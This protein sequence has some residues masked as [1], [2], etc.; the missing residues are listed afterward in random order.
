MDDLL[1]FPLNYLFVFLW[2]LITTFINIIAPL[3][4]SAIVTPVTA[5]FIDPQRAIGIGAYLFFINGIHR[6]Y[7]FRKEIFHEQQ[8]I[9][10]LK[11]LLP[12]TIIG[13]LAGG[14]LIVYINTQILIA[15]V[16]FTSLHFIY[17]AL[18]GI[19]SQK[20]S[21]QKK[22]MLPESFV[23]LLTGFL[24]SSGMPGSDIRNNYLRTKISELS[25]RGVSSCAGLINFFIS[26]SIL[27]LHNRLTHLDL[28]FILITAPCLIP[29]QAYGKRFLEK[30]SD[31]H[32]KLLSIALSIVGIV[33]LTWKY[34]L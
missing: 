28:I 23:F 30:M 3:S 5:F 4:G 9:T 34:F 7:L 11:R 2:L 32:A 16:I 18:K 14:Y 33:L 21:L 29:I 12:Y 25:V 26:G 31:T 19:F 10:L 17:K 22:D 6:V 8:N 27:L 20:K 15:I 13:A 24:Q 1:L